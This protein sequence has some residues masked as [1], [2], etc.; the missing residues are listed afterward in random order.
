VAPP[1][2]SARR[3]PNTCT[4]L[5]PLVNLLGH[6]LQVIAHDRAGTADLLDD[7][8]E[9]VD[10]EGQGRAALRDGAE[11]TVDFADDVVESGRHAVQRVDEQRVEV[12]G[13]EDAL[14]DVGQVALEGQYQF[15]DRRA[16]GSGWSL[17]R[18]T[19]NSS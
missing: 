13:L 12:E 15:D 19:I 17:P 6:V 7:V 14:D 10:E 9:V 2:T 16:A 3:T 8:A 5:A 1:K 4:S 18:R 11:E